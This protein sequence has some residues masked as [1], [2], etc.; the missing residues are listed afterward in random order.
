MV[1]G[2]QGH[3]I[4]S[5]SWA[6]ICDDSQ[7]RSLSVYGALM[8]HQQYTRHFAKGWEETG[9]TEIDKLGMELDQEA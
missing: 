2:M 8:E 6:G 9:D 4:P 1:L 7:H 3:G 5:Y